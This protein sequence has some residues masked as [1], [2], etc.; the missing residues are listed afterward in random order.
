M[1][2]LENRNGSYRSAFCYGGKKYAFTLGEVSSEEAERKSAQVDYLLLRLKQRLVEIPAGMDI[3]EFVQFDGKAVPKISPPEVTLTLADLQGK[4]FETNRK[5]LEQT[6]ID[7]IEVHFRH[8]EGVLGDT[9]LH[10]LQLMDLQK[11]VDER[12]QAF[13]HKG[14]PLSPA[15]IKKEI[16]SLRTA[17]NWA[18]RMGLLKGDFPYRGLRYPKGTEKPPFMTLQEIERRITWGVTDAEKAE[19]YEA[20]YLTV[21]ELPGLLAHVRRRDSQPFVYPMFCFAAHTGARRSES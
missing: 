6:T 1:A 2:S 13:G 9:N 20:L 18:V 14:N 11:Y 16:I 3:V 8:L 10:R 21:D 17:W 7:S 4:Y 5:S 15:T 12:T 19:L